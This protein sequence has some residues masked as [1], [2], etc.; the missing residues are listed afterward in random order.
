MLEELIELVARIWYTD[1]QIRNRSA[2][3]NS[4]L[5]RQSRRLVGWLCG[6]AIGL[7]VL[8][9]IVWWWFSRT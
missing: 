2:L 8:A 6:G 1:S 7:L 3:G 4:K 9:W 5:E